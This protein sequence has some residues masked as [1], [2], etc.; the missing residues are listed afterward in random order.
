MALPYGLLIASENTGVRLNAASVN[1]FPSLL[2]ANKK[3][4]RAGWAFTNGD[5]LGLNAERGAATAGRLDL[6]VL[7]LEPGC[8]QGLDVVDNAAIEVH[9]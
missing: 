5:R 2:Q 9:Q 1:H 3:P 4:I 8:F 7:K 6:G